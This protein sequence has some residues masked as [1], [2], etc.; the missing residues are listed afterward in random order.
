MRCSWSI[1]D[2]GL[3][4]YDHQERVVNREKMVWKKVFTKYLIR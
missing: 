3:K 2:I 1:E 4:N